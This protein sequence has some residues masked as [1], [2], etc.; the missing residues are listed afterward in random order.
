MNP[1][2]NYRI[3]LRVLEP[4]YDIETTGIAFASTHRGMSNATAEER[5]KE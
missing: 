1:F 5:L 2:S 3:R 4:G